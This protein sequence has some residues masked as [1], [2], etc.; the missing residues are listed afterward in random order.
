MM[1][2]KDY[3]ATA[4]IISKYWHMGQ[5][6]F[7]DLISDFSNMFMEDNPRFSPTVF[8]DACYAKFDRVELV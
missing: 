7:E 6:D 2:R 4:Q 8:E 5:G 3:I 1:T